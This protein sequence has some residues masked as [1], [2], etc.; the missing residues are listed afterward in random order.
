MEQKNAKM[1]KINILQSLRAV[2]I[3]LICIAHMAIHKLSFLAAGGEGVSFFIVLSGFL[4]G[5]IYKNKN[6]DVSMS[7]SLSFLF[8]KLRKFYPLHLIV[9]LFSAILVLY[10]HITQYGFDIN[11]LGADIAKTILNA[12]LIQVYI[13]IKGWYMNDIH[14]VGW[15]LSCIAFCYAF[16]LAGLRIIKM[17][18]DKKK[19]ALLFLGVMVLFCCVV[20]IFK[21]HSI[22]TFFLYVFPPVRYLE[23]FMAMILGYNYIE[24]F[25]YLKKQKEINYLEIVTVGLWILNHTLIKMGFFEK[26]GKYDYLTI[27]ICSILIVYVFSKE[28][29]YLSRIL[30]NRILI[31]IGNSSFY[32]YIMHQVIIL[33]VMKVLG[34]N[35]FGAIASS[36][37]IFI[38][39]VIV[40]KISQKK[41][42]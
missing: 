27:F 14:G 19:S 29:G 17:A 38:F 35:A 25:V 37:I 10:D 13:P 11:I 26:V 9:L 5:Y 12:L 33:Y 6:I 42:G 34:W 31:G 21:D 22:E 18:H 1:K 24:E 8:R 7:S 15:F 16:S 41:K 32:V 2:F 40:S 20:M 28:K 3:V 30:D 23:Y 39:T 4:T 36:I